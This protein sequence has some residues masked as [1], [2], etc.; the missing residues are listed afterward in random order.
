MLAAGGDQEQVRELRRE[1]FGDEAVQRFDELDQQRAQ[2]QARINT[3]LIQRTN[4]L[5]NQG[6][7]KDEF[8]IERNAKV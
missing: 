1:M 4:I 3:Y 2:W 7:A 5:S 6:L 8:N